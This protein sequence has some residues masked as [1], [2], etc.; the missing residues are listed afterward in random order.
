M[1]VRIG[2]AEPARMA[3]NDVPRRGL[4]GRGGAILVECLPAGSLPRFVA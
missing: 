3:P 4:F 2:L 1:R